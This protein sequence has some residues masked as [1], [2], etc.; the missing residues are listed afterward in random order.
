MERTLYTLAWLEDPPCA[1]A[2]PPASVKEK[3][4]LHSPEPYS[5]TA[6]AKY[7]PVLR[8]PAASGQRTQPGHS[9]H[10]ALEHRLSR[11]CGRGC[12]KDSS[13][14]SRAPPAC[15]ATRLGTHQPDRRLNLDHQQ[16]ISHGWLQT[17]TNA[18]N[19]AP[20][21]SAR[22]FPF[23][24]L[25]PCCRQG[26]GSTAWRPPCLRQAIRGDCRRR[27]LGA[28]RSRRQEPGGAAAYHPPDSGRRSHHPARHRRAERPRD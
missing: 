7:G 28:L 27:S 18:Q 21:L 26:A 23:L 11:T 12:R 1:V 25:P 4:A 9:S 22:K 10:H 17:S 16:T 24:E 8:K 2:L 13:H 6:L 19:P 14:R 20:I 3:P 15:L 5:S